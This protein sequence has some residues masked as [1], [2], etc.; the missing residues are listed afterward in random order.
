MD[1]EAMNT[2][3][4]TYDVVS[5]SYFIPLA[6]M[7]SLEINQSHVHEIKTV[8]NRNGCENGKMLL[9]LNK[10]GYGTRSYEV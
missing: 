2:E 9:A 3:I 6:L 4:C 1:C 8:I 5:A 7:S 10:Y